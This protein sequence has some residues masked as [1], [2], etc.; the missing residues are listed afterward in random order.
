MIFDP[1]ICI[2]RLR[3]QPY[4]YIMISNVFVFLIRFDYVLDSNYSKGFSYD[5]FDDER[6]YVYMYDFRNL[7]MYKKGF[8]M[9][10]IKMSLKVLGQKS[11][12]SCYE[13]FASSKSIMRP[14]N[15]LRARILM[16]PRIWFATS[17][18]SMTSYPIWSR[19]KRDL[20]FDMNS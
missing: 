6:V 16:W 11:I 15:Y 12:H 20:V 14:R 3:N 8:S 17:Q 2:Y 13:P 19:I 1:F 9:D 7:Y 5:W 4:G 10:L 18:L